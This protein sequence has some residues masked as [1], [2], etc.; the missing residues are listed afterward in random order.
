VGHVPGSQWHACHIPATLVSWSISEIRR[1][2][3]NISSK[4]TERAASEFTLVVRD[5]NS[6]GRRL[7]GTIITFCS[8]CT[9]SSV[10]RKVFL[11]QISGSC[12]SSC[13]RLPF[14]KKIED[15]IAYF[16]LNAAVTKPEPNVFPRTHRSRV[17]YP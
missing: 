8:I 3:E 16:T 11:R 12:P 7:Y 5:S 2:N 13:H 1:K 10:L 14:W 9:I 4:R 15:R 17:D 6:F